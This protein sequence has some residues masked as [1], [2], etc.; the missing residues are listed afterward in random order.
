MPKTRLYLAG[1]MTGYPDWNYPAFMEV[2]DR[3][4]KIG[5]L[6]TNPARLGDPSQPWR[7]NM[8]LSIRAM[9][10][11]DGV[12]LLSGWSTSPGARLEYQ[13]ARDLGIAATDWDVW[14]ILYE[15]HYVEHFLATGGD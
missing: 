5:F 13:V 9:L 8:R 10:E 3:L 11:C 12:A 14:I 7:I 2:E 4:T 15:N 6:V 1:P